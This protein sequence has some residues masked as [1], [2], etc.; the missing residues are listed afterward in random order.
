MSFS[1]FRPSLRAKG[2]LEWL[3]LSLWL[4]LQPS[5]RAIPGSVTRGV[6]L[7]HVYCLQT[8][9]QVYRIHLS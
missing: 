6:A 8:V 4:V 9:A 2:R 5:G 7:P 3:W 1:T